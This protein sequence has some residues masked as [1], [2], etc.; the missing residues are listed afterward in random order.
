MIPLSEVFNWLNREQAS[1]LTNKS[2]FSI[3]QINDP[4]L[5][6]SQKD[7]MIDA[8][9]NSTRNCPD[10]AKYLEVL[11]FAGKTQAERHRLWEAKRHL[12]L[13]ASKFSTL[14]DPFRAAVT[15]W[16]LSMIEW[17]MADNNTA[18]AN[19]RAAQEAFDKIVQE[20]NQE[21]L[22]KKRSLAGLEEQARWFANQMNRMNATL[23]ETPE[24]A[25]HWLNRFE[26]SYLSASS[27]KLKAEIFRLVIDRDFY[28]VYEMLRE[29][30]EMVRVSLDPYEQ[31]EV[32]AF[33]GLIFHQMGNGREAEKNF[34]MSSSLFPPDR[35]HHTT[36]RWMQA[37]VQA[38]DRTRRSDAVRMGNDCVRCFE[39]LR[40]D[41]DH[42]N[43]TKECCWYE[44]QTIT[45]RRVVNGIVARI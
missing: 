17:Q 27:Q 1:H 14:N 24:E 41:S 33:C 31:A 26:E 22:D 44:N 32:Y 11:V 20:R 36:V 40:L 25:H 15:R 37:M 9:I 6:E 7:G 19:A 4:K 28:Q 23:V 30:Q 16:M 45:L 43:R 10:E 42:R 12:G 21:L 29:M 34:R 13:A 38:Q 39:W 18:Y 2:R 3:W 5:P 35:H 8:L